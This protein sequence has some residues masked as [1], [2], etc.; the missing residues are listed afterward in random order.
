MSSIAQQKRLVEQLRVERNVQR[1]P[2]S[3]SLKD[4]ISFTEQ[5]KDLDPLIVGIDK[6]ANPFLEKSSCS[7]L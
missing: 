5:N 4:L 1:M 3:R 6:K 7:I 2:L